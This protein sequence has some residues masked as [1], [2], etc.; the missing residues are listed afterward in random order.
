MGREGLMPVGEEV[1]SFAT[2]PEAQRAV[3]S[4]S[5]DGFPVQHLAIIG[6]DL[7][8]VERITGRK[9]WGRVLLS[10]A[11]SGLWIGLFFAAMMALVGAEAGKGALVM[12]V[13]MGVL[14]GTFFQATGYALSRGRRD[15]TSVSQVVAARY[16][17]I[18]QAHASSAAQAL[19][20]FPGNLTRGGQ[21]AVRAR[22]RRRERSQEGPTAFGSRPDEQPRFGVRLPEGVDPAQY[23]GQHTPGPTASPQPATPKA[24]GP[25]TAPEAPES[26]TGMGPAASPLRR[27]EEPTAGGAAA[28]TPPQDETGEGAPPQPAPSSP[29]QGHGAVGQNDDPYLHPARRRRDEDEEPR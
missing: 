17:I 6:T 27:P 2:Y 16:S 26:T 29:A 1:A 5:D 20:R 23:V 7:R 28:P 13:L 22:E 25:T 24:T 4:L 10:G 9:T 18:A 15:F 3:D 8:Q 14:W 19:A 21:A 12:A 11:A